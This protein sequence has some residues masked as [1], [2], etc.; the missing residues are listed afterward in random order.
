MSQ[1]KFYHKAF[2]EKNIN[3]NILF[4]DDIKKEDDKDEEEE[5]K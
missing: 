1:Y 5:F 3:K 4:A 2:E